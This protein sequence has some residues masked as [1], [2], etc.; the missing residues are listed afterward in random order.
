MTPSRSELRLTVQSE[1]KQIRD[2]Y[3]TIS[4]SVTKEI[5][6]IPSASITFIGGKTSSCQSDAG[7]SKEFIPGKE[8]E[9]LAGYGCDEAV[10]F[11]G[12][13]IRH[14]Q[15]NKFTL[16]VE[17]KDKAVKMTKCRKRVHHQGD[18]DK[19]ILS[20]LIK[21]HGLDAD[22]S[23]TGEPC[24]PIQYDATDWD[25]LLIRAEANGLQVIVTDGRVQLAPVESRTSPVM[26]VKNGYHLYNFSAKLDAVSQLKSVIAHAWDPCEQK[27]I[28]A[29]SDNLNISSQGNLD[30][31]KLSKIFGAETLD[32][33]LPTPMKQ[34]DLKALANAR[35]VR[36]QLSRIQGSMT[37]DGDARP[38]PGTCIE[39]KN[40]SDQFEGKVY[41]T[42]LTHTLSKGTWKT[43]V[44]FGRPDKSFARTPNLSTPA[45]GGLA[46][47][48]SGLHIGVVTRLDEDP[49]QA[50][51]IQVEIP[52]LGEQSTH[53]WARLA[54]FHASDSF[55]AFF[56]PEIGDEVILGFLN[57]DPGN[58]VILGSLYSGKRQPPVPLDKENN[59]K[60]I[61][62]REKMELTFDEKNKTIL[63]KTPGN[64]QLSLSDSDKAVII[65]DQ[66]GNT[67]ELSSSGISLD[68]PK[69]ISISGKNISIS[70]KAG[71]KLD[72]KQAVDISAKTDATIKGLNVTAQAQVGATVKGNA[73]AELSAAGQTTVKGVMVMIN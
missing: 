53:L 33:W 3:G 63:L 7:D 1:G 61:L 28:K 39:L 24:N 69:D 47:P 11:K 73:T 51:R 41:V 17:C 31:R 56:I 65:K 42:G 36:A 71:I 43:D 52:T 12:L 27:M 54:N 32:I 57:N 37:I 20:K 66:N 35:L 60:T 34:A 5:G 59:I 48:I 68:S 13:V 14:N 58:P 40:V 16:S 9:I 64:N 46:P 29:Q 21:E 2:E 23:K 26:T 10:I 62:T 72:A 18:N 44:K 55:G 4:V 25:Y 15:V 30:S 49:D 38:L 6:K 19:T 8:I 22:V 70:A 50:N 45:A 67:V